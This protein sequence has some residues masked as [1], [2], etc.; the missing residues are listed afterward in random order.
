MEL[1]DGEVYHYHSKLVM[2]DAK[3]GGSHLWHQDYG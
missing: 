2:K 3:T 1:L